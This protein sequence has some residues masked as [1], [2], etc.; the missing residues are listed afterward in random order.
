M[1]NTYILLSILFI[2]YLYDKMTYFNITPNDIVY[3]IDY[4]V[5]NI[6]NYSKLSIYNRIIYPLTKKYDTKFFDFNFTYEVINEFLILYVIPPVQLQTEDLYTNFNTVPEW[7][8][9]KIYTD[10]SRKP[11]VNSI[12]S[13]PLEIT[14]SS[15]KK[16][17]IYQKIKK[18]CNCDN[19][20]RKPIKINGIIYDNLCSARCNNISEE[21]IKIG[22]KDRMDINSNSVEN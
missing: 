22:L 17:N 1:K 3:R 8:I 19:V 18:E 5:K 11:T 4:N 16:K 13:Y 9:E 10:K 20:A 21:L 12:L 6:H 7:K 2:F 15:F 14:T